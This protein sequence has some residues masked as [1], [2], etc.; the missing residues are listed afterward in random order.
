[1]KWSLFRS[2]HSMSYTNPIFRAKHNT[3]G[4][5]PNTFKLF[6]MVVVYDIASV[7]PE[8]GSFT[9]RMTVV[10]VLLQVL[11]EGVCLTPLIKATFTKVLGK[12]SRIEGTHRSAAKSCSLN[13]F[14]FRKLDSRERGMQWVSAYCV[15][16]SFSSLD[17]PLDSGRSVARLLVQTCL[18][19]KEIPATVR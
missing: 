12:G 14:S 18:M 4:F 3:L 19:P 9:C 2:K 1:M 13:Y 6:L 11:L 17:T 5:C 8:E 15:S 10:S 7:T 16:Q